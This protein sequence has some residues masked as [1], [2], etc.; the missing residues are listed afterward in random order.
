VITSLRFIARISK[1]TP[2][3]ALEHGLPSYPGW[4]IGEKYEEF[5]L[6]I[7]LHS[8]A[9]GCTDPEKSFVY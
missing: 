3:R 6:R 5:L 9:R 7:T 1:N 2:I 8:T 4:H